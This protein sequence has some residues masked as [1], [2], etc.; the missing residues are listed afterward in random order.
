MPLLLITPKSDD[1]QLQIIVNAQITPTEY[2][3]QYQQMKHAI[4]QN[5]EERN[6]ALYVTY[7]K[8]RK[9]RKTTPSFLDCYTT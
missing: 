4:H 7:S 1:I 9:L 2:N 8:P 5:K 6:V 3:V